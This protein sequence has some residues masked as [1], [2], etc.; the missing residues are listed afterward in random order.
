M[1][2]ST[3]DRRALLMLGGAVILILLVEL[4]AG[5]RDAEPAMLSTDS[6]A[7]AEKRLVR[8]KQ[9]ASQLPALEAELAA[10]AAALSQREKGILQADTL[11]QAQ[12]QLLQVAGRVSGLQQP[13]I[14]IRSVEVARARPLDD[15]YGEISVPIAFQCRIEQLVNLLADLTAQPEL[16]ATGDLRLSEADPKQKTLNVRLTLTAVVLRKLVP[17]KRGPDAL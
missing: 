17:E 5:R 11:P 10:A 8:V 7:A 16:L 13:P 9:E 12:A 14:D 3:R 15:N 1:K 6:V 2:L 4:V